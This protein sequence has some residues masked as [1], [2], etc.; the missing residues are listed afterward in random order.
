V[1]DVGLERK[2]LTA[3][4]G[5][6]EDM[7]HGYS[8]NLAEDE[9]SVVRWSSHLQTQAAVSAWRRR[10]ALGLRVSEKRVLTECIKAIDSA[11]NGLNLL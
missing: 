7:L 10:V 5:G 1:P 3:L 4:R 11:F 8:T 6:V 9:A 2:I